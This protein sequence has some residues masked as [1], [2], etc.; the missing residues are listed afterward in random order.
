MMRLTGVL[1]LL[2]AVAIPASA[3]P[4]FRVEALTGAI[5]GFLSSIVVDSQGTIYCTTLQGGILRI[6]AD[7]SAVQVASVVTSFRGNGGLLGMALVNDMTA[8]V[9]YTVPHPISTN[10][11]LSDVI[12]L[13]DL[14]TGVET[15]LVDFLC[16]LDDPTGGSSDEHHGGNPT[17]GPD[18]AIYVGIGEYGGRTIAQDPRWNGGK[19]WRIDLAGY[20]TQWALGMRNPYD[21]AFDPALDALVVSDNGPEGGDEI[22]IVPFSANCGW[23]FT[24]G[25]QAPMSGAT[26]PAYVFPET[27]A[28][29]GLH[30]LGGANALLPTGY[31]SG[32]YVTSA[33]YYFPVVSPAETPAPATL[34]NAFAGP[35]IDVT[36]TP[37]GDVVFAASFGATGTIYRLVPPER[38]DCNGDFAV[39]ARDFVPLLLEIGDGVPRPVYSSARSWGCDVNGDLI[40]DA[41]DL[42]ALRAMLPRKRRAF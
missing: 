21:L 2:A 41:S 35:V 7:G 11:I 32:S 24:S 20:A 1:L 33:I 28:P 31:L 17:I 10:L 37:A 3:E 9:H 19:L 38:G 14:S 8:A 16:D 22:N 4:G 42:D 6:E 15:V 27:V 30:R 36:E 40:I 23:P 12:A 18:G 34:L 13:V 25:R 39:N 5:P 26:E 29:T